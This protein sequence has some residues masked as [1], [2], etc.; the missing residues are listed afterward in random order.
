VKFWKMRGDFVLFMF[1]DV[2]TFIYLYRAIV[3][4]NLCF[5]YLHKFVAAALLLMNHNIPSDIITAF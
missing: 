4:K 3:I 2:Y 5:F 1:V